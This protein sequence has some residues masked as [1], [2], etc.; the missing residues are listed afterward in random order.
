ME[1]LLRHAQIWDYARI[2][3]SNEDL[4]DNLEF[5]AKEVDM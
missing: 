1:E 4:I 3:M 2:G 5:I